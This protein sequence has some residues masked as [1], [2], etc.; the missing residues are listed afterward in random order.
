MNRIRF[1][2]LGTIILAL[3]CSRGVIAGLDTYAYAAREVHAHV[4]DK[5][6]EIEKKMVGAFLV[7]QRKKNPG[8]YPLIKLPCGGK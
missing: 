2:R 1:S 7:L 8:P 4:P 3:D 6:Q 5:K